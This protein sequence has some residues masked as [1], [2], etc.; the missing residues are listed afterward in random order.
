M[1]STFS[2]LTAQRRSERRGASTIS[3]PTP[4]RAGKSSSRPTT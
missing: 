3:A 1:K 2:L 4:V